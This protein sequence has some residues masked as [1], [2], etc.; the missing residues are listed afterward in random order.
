MSERQRL[1]VRETVRASDQGRTLRA[2]EPDEFEA[3]GTRI[4]HPKVADERD[5]AAAAMFLASRTD[6]RRFRVNR[7]HAQGAAGG[8]ARN[9]RW[10]G[11]MARDGRLTVGAGLPREQAVVQLGLHAGRDG[12]IFPRR[13]IARTV[14]YGCQTAVRRRNDRATL[15]RRTRKWRNWQTR[16]T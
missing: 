11:F 3:Q 8:R 13:P 12:S 9:R 15:E 4:R 5:E 10:G 14:R 16:R 7:R 1:E 6:R 2:G